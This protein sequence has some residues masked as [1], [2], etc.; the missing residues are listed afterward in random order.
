MDGAGR[1]ARSMRSLG[2][3]ADLKAAAIGAALLLR[4]RLGFG[5]RS[6]KPSRERQ[7]PH[8]LF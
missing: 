7:S 3:Q 2:P 1:P 8:R 4:E 6:A 5:R